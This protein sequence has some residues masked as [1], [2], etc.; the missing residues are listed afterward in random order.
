MNDKPFD[1]DKDWTWVL[2]E[3]CPECEF[4]VRYFAIEDVSVM[5]RSIAAD[6][7]EVLRYDEALLRR[8]PQE[9]R[10]SALEYAAHVR[11]VFELYDYRLG[12]ML[13]EDGPHYPNWDQDATAVDKDYASSDPAEVAVALAA[14]AETLASHFESVSGDDWQ[15]TGFRSDG[16]AFTVETFAR[17]LVHDPAHHFRDVLNG[18]DQIRS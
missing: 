16:A 1:D 15:R 14:N 13:A 11:D 7:T 9:D 18:F 17:Y 5:I 2:N 6:W 8:R 10:W 12:L 4:E 3:M